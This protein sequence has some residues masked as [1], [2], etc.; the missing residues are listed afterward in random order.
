MET[1]KKAKLAILSLEDLKEL[2]VNKSVICQEEAQI[3]ISLGNPRY[4]Q[5]AL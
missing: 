3:D 2:R 5:D 4:F 1:S